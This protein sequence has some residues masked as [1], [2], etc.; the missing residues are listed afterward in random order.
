MR[1]GERVR[2]LREEAHLSQA[3]VARRSGLAK[4]FVSQ[5]ERG[6]QA[7]SIASLDRIARALG[8]SLGVLFEDEPPPPRPSREEALLSAIVNE[9]RG[10]DA[11]YLIGVRAM[12]RVLDRMME[13]SAGD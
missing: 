13:G 12:L 7:A 3:E 11:R 8:L 9:L 6:G 2:A 1:V 5:V 10:H 4:S